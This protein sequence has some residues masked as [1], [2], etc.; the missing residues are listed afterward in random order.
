[1]GY[2]ALKR[3]AMEYSTSALFYCQE[4]FEWPLVSIHLYALACVISFRI[5]VV[6]HL[7]WYSMAAS[8]FIVGTFLNAVEGTFLNAVEFNLACLMTIRLS[9]LH[10]SRQWVNGWFVPDIFYVPVQ[11]SFTYNEMLH[12][13]MIYILHCISKNFSV[14]FIFMRIFIVIYVCPF[15][16]MLPVTRHIKIFMN[17]YFRFAGWWSKEI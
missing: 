8:T 7:A 13:E 11:V 15:I 2:L 6:T 16:L 10:I 1:M 12:L 5:T 17:F 3:Q 14:K 4:I 9:I